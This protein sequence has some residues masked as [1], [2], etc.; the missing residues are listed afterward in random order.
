LHARS[1]SRARAK[2][3]PPHLSPPISRAYTHTKKQDKQKKDA[4]AVANGGKPKQSAGELRLQK[5]AR[6][7]A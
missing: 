3:R 1:I 5:G 7:A 2:P 6:A 4:A